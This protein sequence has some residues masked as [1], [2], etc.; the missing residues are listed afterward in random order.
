MKSSNAF[1]V[2]EPLNV[3]ENSKLWIIGV[4]IGGVIGLLL[5]GWC[6]L[7]AYYNTCGRAFQLSG[8]SLQKKNA[9]PSTKTNR[10]ISKEQLDESIKSSVLQPQGKTLVLKEQNVQTDGYVKILQLNWSAKLYKG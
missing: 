1:S 7:F 3:E 10:P 5:F 4:V 2:Y 8:P 9:T 6:L